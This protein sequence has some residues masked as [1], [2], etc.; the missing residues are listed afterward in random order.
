METGIRTI[1]TF[2][3]TDLRINLELI[4]ISYFKTIF[5][6]NFLFLLFSVEYFQKIFFSIKKKFENV[7]ETKIIFSIEKF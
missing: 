2:L 1:Q 7:P 6:K 5:W 3:I 4:L